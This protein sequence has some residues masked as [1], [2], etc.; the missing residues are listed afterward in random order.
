[1]VLSKSIVAPPSVLGR[2]QQLQGGGAGSASGQHGT[3]E[4]ED[5]TDSDLEEAR[6]G[7]MIVH[8]AGGAVVSTT[9]T[10]A[11]TSALDPLPDEDSPKEHR[12]KTASGWDEFNWK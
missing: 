6:G 11:A 5:E 1:M 4:V 12:E 3:R 9:D 2:L 10:H 8:R 7:K